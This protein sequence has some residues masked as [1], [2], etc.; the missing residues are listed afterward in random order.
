MSKN[1]EEIKDRIKGALY[2]F[3]IGDAMGATT[4]FMPEDKIKRI[5]GTV[6]N[7]IGGG[8]LKLEAGKGTDD[9]EMTSCVMRALM[10]EDLDN[11]KIDVAEEF[12]EWLETNPK[13]VGNQCFKALSYYN[14][15]NKFIYVDD[16]ALGNGS[17][18][19]ALPCALLN[20]ENSIKLNIMQGEITHNN[21]ICEDIIVE[22]TKII[23]NYVQGKEY[24]IDEK[25]LLSPTGHIVNT[26]NNA[27]YWSETEDIKSCI[28]GAVNHGD[29]SDT[30]AAIAGSISGAKHGYKNIPENWINQLDEKTKEELEIFYKFIIKSY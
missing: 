7:I 13:D 5:Y 24:P 4:E 8:W 30:I 19:R 28:I 9:T 25:T 11:F 12:V 14:K 17:L 26:Y 23:Q 29:D 6:D 22:Y 18:M 27:L 3:V 1:I 20:N 15:N 16:E 2:G 21:K 10:K